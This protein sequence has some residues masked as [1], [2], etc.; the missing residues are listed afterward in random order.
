MP[1][2][3]AI[4]SGSSAT[5]F[6]VKTGNPAAAATR[7]ASSWAS[8]TIMAS[9]VAS[10]KRTL[11]EYQPGAL[12]EFLSASGSSSS[13]QK[14]ARVE[15]PFRAAARAR[16]S[17]SDV[18]SSSEEDGPAPLAHERQEQAMDDEHLAELRHDMLGSKAGDWIG[19]YAA[20]LDSEGDPSDVG[21]SAAD[22]DSGGDGGDNEDAEA[23]AAAAADA[24]QSAA[25]VECP[26]GLDEETFDPN[27]T[28]FVRN[29]SFD[30]DKDAIMHFFSRHEIELTN[31]HVERNS[32]GRS[33]GFAYVQLANAESA[34]HALTICNAAEKAA[35]EN[36]SDDGDDAW[37]LIGR[38]PKV[39]AF[40]AEAL[41]RRQMRRRPKRK[42]KQPSS[43][44]GSA[45]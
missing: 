5:G 2:T 1:N 4:D 43:S 7:I 33:A 44:G 37:L 31:C 38:M 32:N 8:S 17:D 16:S 20:E 42:K 21:D 40:D 14:R 36:G 3:R 35:G 34:T 22:S 15:H 24:A 45:R 28:L 41:M 9:L 6:S 23:A 19:Q 12:G 39:S 29:L 10:G 13:K 26:P 11:A 27:A 30:A 18:G 25:H